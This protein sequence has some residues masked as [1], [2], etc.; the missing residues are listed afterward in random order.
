MSTRTFTKVFL[1]ALVAS[2]LIAVGI[3]GFM[4]AAA[5]GGVPVIVLTVTSLMFTAGLYVSYC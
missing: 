3:F 1:K 4:M 2:L 5:P